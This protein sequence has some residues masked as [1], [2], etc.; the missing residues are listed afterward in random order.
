MATTT[1]PPGPRRPVIKAIPTTYN[2]THFRSRLEARWAAMFDL[3]EWR[4]SYEPQ[5]FRNYIPDFVLWFRTPVFVEVKPVTWDESE[6]EEEILQAARSKIVH[7]GIQGE[8]LL[9]G[10]R[11]TSATEHMQSSPHHRLGLMMDI[12]PATDEASPWGP[13]FGFFCDY[14]KTRSFASEDLS[15]HCRVKGCGGDVGRDHI[16][17]WDADRDFRTAGSATQWKPA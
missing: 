14:C 5:E 9:L 1:E 2:G 13:A 7:S 15:W 4:W 17:P 16:Y 6:A 8:L 11:I 10:T 12:D 3:C